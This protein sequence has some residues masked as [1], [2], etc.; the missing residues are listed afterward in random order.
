MVVRRYKISRLHSLVSY[1]VECSKRNSVSTRVHAIFS[2][3]SL[4][5][6]EAGSEN[7]FGGGGGV[8]ASHG[9]QGD[10]MKYQYSV[11]VFKGKNRGN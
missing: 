4:G 3:L 6:D 7:F 2:I 8:G 1:R 9:F 5:R 10:Q 11:T